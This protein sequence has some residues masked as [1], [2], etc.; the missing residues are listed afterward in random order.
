MPKKFKQNRI[1]STEWSHRRLNI[2][3]NM[4]K[5]IIKFIIPTCNFAKIFI[6]LQLVSIDWFASNSSSRL[7]NKWENP[8]LR[9]CEGQWCNSYADH[10]LCTWGV[11]LIISLVLVVLLLS[12]FKYF[13][14]HWITLAKI[15]GS[16]PIK[17]CSQKLPPIILF[18]IFTKE[19]SNIFWFFI[20]W[21]GE[22]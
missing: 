3:P 21:F 16:N 10:K 22:H 1:R 12:C 17:G 13:V 18:F 11:M 4:A 2:R 6:T 19:I 7:W 15:D 9:R 20:F 14:S 8:I 5:P